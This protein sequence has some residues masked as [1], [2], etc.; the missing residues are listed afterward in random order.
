[1]R[2]LVVVAVASTVVA[3][4]LD[5][6]AWLRV[7]EGAGAPL[8]WDEASRAL[9]TARTVACAAVPWAL[10]GVDERDRAW[11]G[12]GLGLC[13]VGDV[14]LVAG[15]WFIAGVVLFLGAQGV[16]LARAARGVWAGAS[17]RRAKVTGMAL[18]AVAVWG[19]LMAALGPGLSGR[20]LSG[21]VGIYGA[22][23]VA[24]VTTAVLGHGVGDHPGAEGR[25]MVWGMVAFAVCDVLVGVG[26]AA[27][28]DPWARLA[29]L[30]TG[31][32]YTPA[33]L[34]LASSVRRMRG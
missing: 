33:L 31:W 21:V 28:A 9:R 26:A 16:L 27:P 25:R 4:A 22:V 34:L 3:W 7:M 11:V 17:G 2:W 8:G 19:A 10:S 6:A 24:G 32:F 30:H 20:G 23:L 13:A 15:G 5:L 29:R 12:A 18:A 14:A 1:M